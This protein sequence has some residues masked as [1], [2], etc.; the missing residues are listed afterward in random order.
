MR[1]YLKRSRI[2]SYLGII[3]LGFALIPAML[4]YFLKQD[5]SE[6]FG[7]LGL[8]L[9]F[10][11]FIFA[12]II[13]SYFELKAPL[14]PKSV[15]RVLSLVYG[16]LF[17]VLGI[18]YF[19]MISYVSDS[20]SLFESWIVYI[21]Y[22]ISGILGI[23]GAIIYRDS[24][25]NLSLDEQIRRCKIG[26]S[27]IMISSIL[28]VTSILFL[29]TSA[30]YYRTVNV[31]QDAFV[32][33]YH[34]DT[35]YGQDS[36]IYVG[37]YEY[38]RTEAYYQFDL[39]S[40]E[41]N[42]KETKLLVRFDYASNPV[43]AGA[44]I[45]FETWDEL[46]ITWNNKP[47][48]TTLYG[49]IVCDGFDFYVGVKP[50]YFI[51]HKITICLYGIG[52]G[53]DGYLSGTSKECTSDDDIPFAYLEYRGIDPNFYIGY[54]IAYAGIFIVG[55]LYLKNTRKAKEKEIKNLNELFRLREQLQQLERLREQLQRNTRQQYHDIYWESPNKSSQENKSLA[56]KKFDKA[57]HKRTGKTTEN[58]YNNLHKDTLE[59][60][61][62]IFSRYRNGEYTFGK[63]E[64]E[65][66]LKRAFFEGKVF[67]LKGS[68]IGLFP[69]LMFASAIFFGFYL[70]FSLKSISG[71][72]II[73]V[74]SFFGI[75]TIFFSISIKKQFIV[76]GPYG[77]YYRRYFKKKFFLW[78][79]S[80]LTISHYLQYGIKMGSSITLV[81]HN[82]KKLRLHPVQ[83]KIKEF[84]KP[85]KELMFLRLFQI[86][87]E[88][89]KRQRTGYH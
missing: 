1:C 40:L 70:L 45:I 56:F 43:N 77:V 38:G 41:S 88:L 36:Q 46:S 13:F 61:K 9:F 69:C 66:D 83:Y 62:K 35:N 39:S 24:P 44:C 6:L 2:T 58:Y 73:A 55:L 71:L 23:I 19:S 75:F 29:N 74:F 28:L 26:I 84:P 65:H 63:Y 68:N 22:I 54:I 5:Y 80:Y 82:N 47:N 14:V 53:S 4:I 21:S 32:Y 50:K 64:T 78:L 10:G 20:T 15:G 87:H 60:L 16:L 31:S 37:N 17:L 57:Y 30:T 59:E 85:V 3:S 8:G 18:V 72:V 27:A 79:D 42:W 34:P 76:I 49:H 52:G 51:N 33:E 86:Y 11:S 48:Y 12:S 7:Y 67:V 81:T 89:E 25:Q